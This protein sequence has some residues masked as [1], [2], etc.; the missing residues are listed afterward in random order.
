MSEVILDAAG[1]T[2]AVFA[3]SVWCLVLT[4]S[5]DLSLPFV[6]L[7]DHPVIPFSPLAHQLWACFH[8][9]GRPEH[10]GQTDLVFCAL[11]YCALQILCFHRLK[12]CVNLESGKSVVPFSEWHLFLIHFMSL[13]HILVILAVFQTFSAFYITV[14]CDPIASMTCKSLRW[15]LA[16]FSNKTF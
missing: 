10:T 6:V 4:L 16:L 15:W 8:F 9:G 1:L 13:C 11:L 5:S 14:I 7:R 12:V 3:V 2:A